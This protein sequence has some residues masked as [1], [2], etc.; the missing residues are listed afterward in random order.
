[1]SFFIGYSWGFWQLRG[2]GVTFGEEAGVL[3]GGVP[4]LVVVGVVPDLGHI[5]PVDNLAVG[6]GLFEVEDALLGLCLIADICFLLIHADHD[7]GHFGF[8][9]DGGESGTWG[10][11][12]REPSFA[13]A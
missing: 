7:G 12:S 8:P 2:G 4:Q 11:L 10:V 5:L 9:N 3:L 6:D 13:A 1:M